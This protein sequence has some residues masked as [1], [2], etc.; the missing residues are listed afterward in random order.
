M[1]L[2]RR[3][4]GG[5]YAGVPSLTCRCMSRNMSEGATRFAPRRRTVML[6]SLIP[7]LA[8]LLMLTSLCTGCAPPLGT[9]APVSAPSLYEDS[10]TP[11]ENTCHQLAWLAHE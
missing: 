10:F 8:E 7:T 1:H 6:R 9:R 4:C 3:G 5:R 2:P 11:R